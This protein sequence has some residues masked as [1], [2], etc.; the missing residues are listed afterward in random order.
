MKYNMLQK[1]LAVILILPFVV[2]FFGCAP[3]GHKVYSVTGKVLY[4]GE[5]LGNAQISFHPDDPLGFVASAITNPDGTF[6]LLTTGATKPGAI[7]GEYNVLVSKIIAVDDNGNPLKET[8]ENPQSQAPQME[9]STTP[10]IQRPKMKS[11]IPEKYAQI[12]KPLLRATV[13]K[14][15]NNYLF[16]LDDK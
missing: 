4:N 16:E 1:S 11:I 13:A 8:Q 3:S 9:V 10:S 14:K 5:P 12:D 2:L 6:S 15:Q 7:A